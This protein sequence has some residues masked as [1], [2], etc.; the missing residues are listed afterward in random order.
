MNITAAAFVFTHAGRDH[1]FRPVADVSFALDGLWAGG[2]PAGWHILGL[3][4][5]LSNTLL[6]LLLA[7]RLARC[8][9]P[10]LLAAAL[11]GIHG[12]CPE[13]VAFL[14]R[15]DQL[16]ALSVLAGLL[17]FDRYLQSEDG[18]RGALWASYPVVLA[19]LLSKESAYIF[20]VLA[21]L[22]LAFRRQ[23]TR[24]RLAATAGYFAL[25]ALAFAWR[26]SVVGGIGGYRDRATGAPEIFIIHPVLLLKALTLRL[27]G[28]LYFPINWS[29][30]PRPWLAAATLAFLGALLCM[31]L[32]G[33]PCRRAL[34]FAA[35]FAFLASLPVAHMLLIGADL[36]GAA[37]IYLPSAGF[38]LFLAFAADGISHTVG[39][40]DAAGALILFQ[41]AALCHNLP[42]W[43]RTAQLA[44]RSCRMLAREAALSGRT[45]LVRDPPR[46]LD[47][48]PFFAVGLSEC[49]AMHASGS[50]VSVEFSPDSAGPADFVW[51]PRTRAFLRA[52]VDAGMR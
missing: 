4:L 2:N 3:L 50:S 13:S 24:R 35:A 11:F 34:G 25:A 21:L 26:W 33:R 19:G 16:A 47:G 31:I 1:F 38:C 17:L 6:V 42:I 10:G 23:L 52:R 40:R 37:H 15:F 18:A 20:P 45:L 8:V 39:R 49:V 51:D 7:W 27:W 12:S 41:F 9:E 30:Q 32:A 48:I 5:H 44:D 22:L 14:A 46:I 28:V 36:R 29:D 43:S